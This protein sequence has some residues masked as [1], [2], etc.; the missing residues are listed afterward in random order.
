MSQSLDRIRE[1][2]G[3]AWETFKLDHPNQAADLEATF[4]DDW[5]APLC[6]ELAKDEAYLTL[7]AET[8][9]ETSIAT[10]AAKILPLIFPAVVS[11]LA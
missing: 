5:K 2:V 7:L 8:N 10:L 11:L 6:D 9:D 3:V 4:G 1:A